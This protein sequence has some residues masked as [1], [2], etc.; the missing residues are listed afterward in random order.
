MAMMTIPGLLKFIGACQPSRRWAESFGPRAFCRAWHTCPDGRWLHYLVMEV[1]NSVRLT[2]R[3]LDIRRRMRDA[4]LDY[5]IRTNTTLNEP[6]PGRVVRDA[7]RWTYVRNLLRRVEN[8]Y[9]F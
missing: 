5:R 7:V 6:M 3:D 9:A 1:G 4:E 2:K 8:M